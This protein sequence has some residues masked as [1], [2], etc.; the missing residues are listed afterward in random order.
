MSDVTKVAEQRR[1][2]DPSGRHPSADR[3]ADVGYASRT[4]ECGSGLAYSCF[5]RGGTGMCPVKQNFRSRPSLSFARSSLAEFCETK[6]ALDRALLVR[7]RTFICL[8]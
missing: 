2:G 6:S 3:S 4:E 7:L 8:T 1:A 5:H